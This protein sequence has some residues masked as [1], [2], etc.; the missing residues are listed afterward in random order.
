MAKLTMRIAFCLIF[1]VAALV[2]L[3]KGMFALTSHGRQG[4]DRFHRCTWL[5]ALLAVCAVE[6]WFV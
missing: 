5:A 3:G 4:S 6:V 2:V 1:L